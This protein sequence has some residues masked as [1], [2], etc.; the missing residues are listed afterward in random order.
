MKT[1][2][3]NRLQPEV[4][5]MCPEIHLLKSNDREELVLYDVSYWK[6][7]QCDRMRNELQ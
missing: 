4:L 5:V 6:E 7:V 1:L 3:R 2:H